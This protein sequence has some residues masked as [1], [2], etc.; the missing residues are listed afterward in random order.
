M[1][2]NDII[3]ESEIDNGEWLVKVSTIPNEK[4]YVNFEIFDKDNNKKVGMFM[5]LL[6]DP[7]LDMDSWASSALAFIDGDK[8]A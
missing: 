8:D 7:K 6:G 1:T 3:W 2:T 5:E 4:E